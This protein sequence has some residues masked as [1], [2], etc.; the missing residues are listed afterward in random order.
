MSRLAIGT[1]ALAGAF[2]VG[3][4]VTVSPTGPAVPT[5]PAVPTPA[6]I[7]TQPPAGQTSAPVVTPGTQPV[8]NLCHILT[9]D[10][11][12]AAAG[13]LPAVLGEDYDLEGECNWDVGT[14]ND[15]GIRDAFVNLRVDFSTALEEFRTDWPG[16]EDL[17]IGED[18][19]WN[20]PLTQLNFKVN[21]RVYAVQIVGG[22]DEVDPRALAIAIAT[23]AASRL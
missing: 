21:G 9:L 12:S 19:Y 16:G 2:V 22:S 10:E 3:A 15:L 11:I 4:C 18:A 1:L 5:A 20:P 23:T 7:Q 6:G 14:P 13:G 8:G 17:A